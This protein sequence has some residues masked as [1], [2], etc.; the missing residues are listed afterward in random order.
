MLMTQ[1]VYLLRISLLTCGRPATSGLLWRCYSS[2][3]SRGIQLQPMASLSAQNLFLL[4]NSALKFDYV[5]W[6]G[7]ANTRVIFISRYQ[8]RK[9]NYLH[10]E[11]S[12][13]YTQCFEYGN[14]L[15][16]IFDYIVRGE[17]QIFPWSP[18]SL[19]FNRYRV[20]PGGK[21]AGAWL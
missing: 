20:F 13:D 11:T 17:G 18:H 16:S 5:V 1:S 9:F 21:T 8:L 19:L 15:P 4:E 7:E 3:L 2:V 12:K 6:R 14:L 10:N